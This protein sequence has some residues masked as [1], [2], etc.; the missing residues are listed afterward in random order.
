MSRQTTRRMVLQ[1]VTLLLCMGVLFAGVLVCLYYFQSGGNL[2]YVNMPQYACVDKDESGNYTLSVDVEGI[3]QDYHLPDPSTTE[4]D[5]TRYPDVQALYSLAFLVTQEGDNYHIS[6]A[7]TLS[8]DPAK[9]LKKGG[10]VLQNT[11]WTWTSSDMTAAYA[12]TLEGLRQ[13]SIQNYVLCGKNLD[14]GYLLTVDKERLLKYC[15]W[16]LPENEEERKNHKGYEAI[17]SL[18][19]YV[20]EA[21]NGYRVETTST[22]N[23]VVEVLA[24]YGVEIRDTVWVWSLETIEALYQQQKGTETVVVPI[25][26]TEASTEPSMTPTA[27]PATPTPT[28]APTNTPTPTPSA[29]E[30]E[31]KELESR[32]DSL[33]SL[34]GYD[35]TQ[36][37]KA[38]QKAKEEYYG[39]SFESSTVSYNFFVVGKNASAQYGNCFV[40][41]YTVKTAE[42]TEYLRAEVYNFGGDTDITYKDVCLT[43]FT[44]SSKAKSNSDFSTSLYT[45][46]T[47]N[48]GSMTFSENSNTD[49]FTQEG[50]VFDNSLE[51]KLTTEDLWDIPAN[52]EYTL[53]QLLGYARNEI[54]ARSGHKFKDTSNYY[55]YYSQYDW[56][57]PTGSIS[58]NDIVKTGRTNIDLIKDVEELIKEG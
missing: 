6:T 31:P 32:E 11:Q 37:R 54:F 9:A 7:S 39:D 41:V 40:V 50:L 46:Y 26:S 52:G 34:Y 20:T 56:Y 18:G 30:G 55:T 48:G 42:G 3:I 33:T 58:Y 10:L 13:I 8:S 49:P 12:K 43:S 5:L 27:T 14:G 57:Q 22:L 15:R 51:E 23:N 28:V 53:L 29:T 21:E 36:L 16:D 4:L 17:M 2:R 44:S 45:I 19:F 35:Q 38:I 47:L 1:L 24:Q 25:P